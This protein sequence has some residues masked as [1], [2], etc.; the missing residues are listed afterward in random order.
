MLVNTISSN[1]VSHKSDFRDPKPRSRPVFTFHRPETFTERLKQ[2]NSLRGRLLDLPACPPRGLRA[3]QINAITRLEQSFKDNRP[4]A[5]NQMATGSGKTF[6]AITFIYRL[7]KYA[8]AGRVF[9]TMG[10]QCQDRK[11]LSR[12]RRITII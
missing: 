8:D 10:R 7:L 2:A 11:V 3:C 5:L 4:R 9:H 1:C 6:T 12:W